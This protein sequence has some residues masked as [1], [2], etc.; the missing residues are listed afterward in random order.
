MKNFS[1]IIENK[2][3]D[4]RLVAQCLNQLWHLLPQG[5]WYYT[6]TTTIIIIIVIPVIVVLLIVVQI[7][8]VSRNFISYV[9][10][11]VSSGK[12]FLRN[13][14]QWIKNLTLSFWSYH[15][16]CSL[17]NPEVLLGIMLVLNIAVNR[18]PDA[19]SHNCHL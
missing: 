8:Y 5:N 3:H 4:L 1:D 11:N 14:L 13:C 19:N 6:I 17:E 16:L 2:K 15:P 18:M 10:E 7:F 12:G 9:L